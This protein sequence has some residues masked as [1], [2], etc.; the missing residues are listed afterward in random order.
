MPYWQDNKNASTT[1][2]SSVLL[3]EHH[4]KLCKHWIWPIRD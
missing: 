2:S 4:F 1:I 3:S